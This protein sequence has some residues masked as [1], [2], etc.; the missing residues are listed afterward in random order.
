MSIWL[1]LKVVKR[2]AVTGSVRSLGKETPVVWIA[3]FSGG[4]KIQS[5]QGKTVQ[6]CLSCFSFWLTYLSSWWLLSPSL[7][8]DPASSAFMK[9]IPH[10]AQ[11]SSRRPSTS[12]DEQVVSLDRWQIATLGRSCLYCVSQPGKCSFIEIYICYTLSVRILL[13]SESTGDSI[14]NFIYASFFTATP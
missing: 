7:T 14:F 1:N 3:P 5:F 2:L 8:L 10:A 4:S 12:W 11:N 6:I 13:Q 9:S